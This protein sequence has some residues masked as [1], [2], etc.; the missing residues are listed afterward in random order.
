MEAIILAGGYGTRLASVLGAFTPKILAPITEST[1]FLD[2]LII[3][4]R[5]NGIKSFVF[6]LGHLNSPIIEYLNDKYSNLDYKINIELS[7]LG[8]GGA[9]KSSLNL[10][11]SE[12]IFII[13]GDTILQTDFKEMLEFHINE[14]ADCSICIKH[15]KNFSRYGSI[16]IDSNNNIEYFI[17]KKEREEGFIN[18]GVLIVNRKIFKGYFKKVFSFENDF[19]PERMIDTNF[20]I[21]GFKTVG[22]FIDIGVPEDLELFRKNYINF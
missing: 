19:I 2:F 15:L 3:Y 4:L 1:T 18:G 20:N 10:C 13:N 5:K 22:N 9:I 16:Q 12:N 6:S 8:T 7:P 14:N 11:K 17:E 21:K